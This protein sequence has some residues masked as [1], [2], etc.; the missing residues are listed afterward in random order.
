[1][2]TGIKGL[3]AVLGAAEG[4]LAVMLY[5]QLSGLPENYAFAKYLAIAGVVGISVAVDAL[6]LSLGSAKKVSDAKKLKTVDDFLR[7]FKAWL[8]EDTPFAEHIKIAIRQLESLKRKQKALRAVLDDSED[9]PF[10]S[11]AADVDTYILGNCKRILNRV[12][13]YDSAEPHKYN[14]HVAYLQ[15][16]LGE[17]AHV[18][19]DFENLILEV[20]QIGDDR[21]AD[22]PCLDE[23]TDALR[24][25]RKSS[26]EIIQFEQTQPPQ[27]MQKPM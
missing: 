15:D 5:N 10:L 9:S 4:F 7:A 13:I 11:V 23:L 20:S 6:V 25:V 12:M 19:S 17:N 21:T 26:E 22:T 16:V 18:L 1:M 14:M 8:D 27:N 3:L 2:K 24:S